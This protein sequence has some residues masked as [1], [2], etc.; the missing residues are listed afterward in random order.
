ME[1]REEKEGYRKTA[2]TTTES[3]TISC[4]HVTTSCLTSNEYRVK[5]QLTFD[6][7]IIMEGNR[8]HPTGRL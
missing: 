7:K 8:L 6:N 3:A 5:V 4:L 2:G 1:S